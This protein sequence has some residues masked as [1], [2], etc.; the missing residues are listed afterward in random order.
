M[1]YYYTAEKFYQIKSNRFNFSVNSTTH[2][3]RNFNDQKLFS[4]FFRITNFRKLNEVPVIFSAAF[5]SSEWIYALV[6][7]AI[8]FKLRTIVGFREAINFNIVFYCRN[9]TNF[10]SSYLVLCCRKLNAVFFPGPHLSLDTYNVDRPVDRLD[11][12]YAQSKNSTQTT[13]SLFSVLIHCPL[14]SYKR[15]RIVGFTQRRK[16]IYP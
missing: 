1:W 7:V 5:N 11:M 15:E 13:A 12:R 16:L 10:S 6:V 8:G 14:F 4:Y 2:L 9:W 3:L